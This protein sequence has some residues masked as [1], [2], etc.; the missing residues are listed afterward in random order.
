MTA[1]CV[2]DRHFWPD[3]KRIVQEIMVRMQRGELARVKSLH[4]HG[5]PLSDKLMR[6]STQLE[7]PS[8][9]NSGLPISVTV[10]AFWAGLIA[11]T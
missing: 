10:H 4:P 5:G 3:D 9:V 2:C 11:K 7:R 1:C 8:F 6:P